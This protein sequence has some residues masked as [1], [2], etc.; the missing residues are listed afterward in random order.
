MIGGSSRVPMVEAAV[1]SLVGED[2]I[3]KNV[4]AD[5]SA[6]MGEFYR[7]AAHHQQ[8]CH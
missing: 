6:V 4:N 5:E 7:T 8:E 2:K 3:A 1:K